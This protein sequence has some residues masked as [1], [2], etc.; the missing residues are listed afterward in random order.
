MIVTNIQHFCLHDGDGIR[1]TVFLKGC[2][3]RCPWCANPE[4]INMNIEKYVE[5]LNNKEIEK[6]YGFNITID[7]LYSEIV[8]DKNFYSNG[9]GV[10]FSGGEPILQINELEDLLIKLNNE[11]INITFET[12]LFVPKDYLV[13]CLKYVDNYIVDVKILDKDLCKKVIDGNIE[14]Y[15]ENIKKLFDNRKNVI[16]RIPLCKEYTAS[17]ENI[18]LIKNFISQYKPQRVEIFSLHS[19]AEKKYNSL[20]IPFKKYE[21]L[22]KEE[23]FIIKNVLERTGVQ[24]EILE[25]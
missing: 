13:K 6:N 14:L 1:T 12:A 20:A 16:F 15:F 11:N 19:L 17:D 9:G 21:K 24:V 2:S 23:L 5:N 8:K 3:L 10:T 7:E 4:N 25:I 22:T 18:D